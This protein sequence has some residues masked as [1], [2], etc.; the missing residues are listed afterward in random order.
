MQRSLEKTV[1]GSLG[2]GLRGAILLGNA[3]NGDNA[4][5][6]YVNGNNGPS[7]TNANYG[8]F[9]S[10]SKRKHLQRVSLAHWPNISQMTARPVATV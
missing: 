7:N 6:L 2:S 10:N 1:G 5:S 9:L 3:N 8:G 4:G